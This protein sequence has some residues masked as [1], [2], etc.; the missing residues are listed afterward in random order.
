ANRIHIQHAAEIV[1]ISIEKIIAV[2]GSGAL[3]MFERNSFYALKAAF[4]KLIGFGFD[5][6][7]DVL[8]RRPAVGWV[9]LEAAAI[10]W[11]VRRCDDD[12]VRQTRIAPAVVCQYCV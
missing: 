1:Y 8:I 10:G 2:R 12:A 9:V 11:I 7:G 3:G 6:F 4:Q 5:P